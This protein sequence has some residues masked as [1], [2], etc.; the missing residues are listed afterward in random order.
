MSTYSLHLGAQYY[1]RLMP[2]YISMELF[3]AGAY[4]L[5][6][7]NILIYNSSMYSTD[8]SSPYKYEKLLSVNSIRNAI[9]IVTECIPT[10]TVVPDLEQCAIVT[11]HILLGY[12]QSVK[13]C[14]K[15]E[16]IGLLRTLAQ[17]Q[18]CLNGAYTT[19]NQVK[20]QFQMYREKS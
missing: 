18:V 8:Y 12:K 11:H 20:L 1:L 6:A 3:K 10:L 19:T 13:V 4:V 17:A 9:N 16:S 14:P 15:H 7:R 5:N 2:I